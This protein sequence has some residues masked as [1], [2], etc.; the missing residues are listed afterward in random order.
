MSDDELSDELSVEQHLAEIQ[1]R[2]A[3][4]RRIALE[5]ADIDD[6]L[7]AI[8]RRRDPGDPGVELTTD[9]IPTDDK[10]TN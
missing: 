1:G 8:R 6:H 7:A 10:E 3:P 4:P 5:D 9:E 2:D